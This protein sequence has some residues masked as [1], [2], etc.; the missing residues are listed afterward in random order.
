M[1]TGVS[2]SGK[3]SLAFDTLYAEGQRRYIESLS[4]YARQ[5]LERIEKPDVDEITGIAPAIAIRQKNSTRNPRSTVAT[6]PKFTITCGCCMRA[7]ATPSAPTAAKKCA[8]TR[9]TK[10][11]R[12]C[13][14]CREGRRFYVLYEL[15]LAP[16]SRR[17]RHRAA[18]CAAARAK[19][20]PSPSA[21]NHPRGARQTCASAASTAS[22][23][24][25]AS[26]NSPRRKNCWTSISRSPSTCWWIGWR[27]RRT[28]ARAWWTRSRSATAKAGAKPSWNSS[29]TQPGGEPERLVFNERFECKKCGAIYQE[30]EPRLFS[31]NNPYGACPRCQGFGNTID[32]DLDRVIPDKGKSLDEGA[33][34]PWTKPRYRSLRMEMRKFRARER[35]S[36]W[37]CPSAI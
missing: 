29:R 9:W 11:P 32:F 2:G 24:P 16:A 14:R 28:F 22:I 10:L 15:K 36:H 6:P 4:A 3:S 26:S 7:W 17:S 5:F 21:G 12:A 23:K 37:T 34:E 19:K 30:P 8:R 25:A 18:D 13:W 31:F 27:C 20:P 33:I 35:H 1:V